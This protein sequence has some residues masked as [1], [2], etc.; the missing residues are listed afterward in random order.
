MGIVPSW[1]RTTSLDEIISSGQLLSVKCGPQ[2]DSKQALAL[3]LGMVKEVL[4]S[5]D[6]TEYPEEA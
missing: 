3:N 6:E 5:S 1:G 4:Q 2:L